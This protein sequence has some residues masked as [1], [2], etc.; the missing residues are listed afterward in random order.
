LPFKPKTGMIKEENAH[1]KPQ[2]AH[3][4]VIERL[5]P[6]LLPVFFCFE[7]VTIHDTV[8]RGGQDN[9][10]LWE[11]MNYSSPIDA[12]LTGIMK[13]MATC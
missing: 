1:P 9:K 10:Y 5:D 2:N 4:I 8:L 7:F 3:A 13:N 12:K 6:G 11:N